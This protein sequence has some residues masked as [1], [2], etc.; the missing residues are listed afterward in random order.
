VGRHCNADE[1]EPD[2]RRARAVASLLESIGQA[3]SSSPRASCG[4]TSVARAAEVL[5]PVPPD[6]VS[7]TP[8]PAD[9]G[10]DIPLMQDNWRP[11]ALP[12]LTHTGRT[13]EPSDPAL[14]RQA[15]AAYQACVSFADAQVVCSSR[16]ST[17]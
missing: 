15:I 8:A 6:Q 10:A 11:L 16:R 7:F 3:R 13:Q 12:G 1:H 14:V 2:G 5:R 9:D 4:R 17:A